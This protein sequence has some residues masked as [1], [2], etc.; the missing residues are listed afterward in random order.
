MTL[1]FK[2]GHWWLANWTQCK[3]SAAHARMP[4][5]NDIPCRQR[6]MVKCTARCGQ[7]G[8][9]IK[10]A[11][12]RKILTPAWNIDSGVDCRTQRYVIHEE[13]I[14]CYLTGRAGR[15]QECE[16]ALREAEDQTLKRGEHAQVQI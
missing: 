13:G 11:S 15:I 8:I 2:Q 5:R 6:R 4:R 1:Y 7:S 3:Q 16:N 9:Q 14:R 12:T 10:G